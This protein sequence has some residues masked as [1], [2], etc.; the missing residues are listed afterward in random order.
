[1]AINMRFSIFF[2]LIFSLT[3]F[4]LKSQSD[5]LFDKFG[6]DFFILLTDS[7]AFP[8]LEYVRNKS[9]NNLID[10]Q[11]L[12]F[13][14]K[15]EWKLRMMTK[16][17]EEQMLFSKKLG[18]LVHRYG[19]DVANGAKAEYIDFIIEP[20]PKWKNWYHC[21]LKMLFQ[22]EDVQSLRS[23]KF[24]LHYTGEGLVFLSTKLKESF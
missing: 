8:P 12:S 16:Y 18:V 14:K 23:I 2:L 3:V 1:M 6:Q 11:E 21:D 22:N 15:E 24:E 17:P 9:M 20:H 13:S 19:T 10:Q 4:K 7:S 5:S